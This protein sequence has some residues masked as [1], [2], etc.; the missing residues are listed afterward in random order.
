MP[1]PSII[2]P[3][4]GVQCLVRAVGIMRTSMAVI[5]QAQCLLDAACISGARLVQG[6]AGGYSAKHSQHQLLR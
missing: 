5:Q 4:G 2:L 3:A 1:P 6:Q